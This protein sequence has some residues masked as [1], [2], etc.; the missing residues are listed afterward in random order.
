[1]VEVRLVCRLV[2]CACLRG[3]GPQRSLSFYPSQRQTAR[4]AHRSSWQK[5]RGSVGSLGRK[6]VL[7]YRTSNIGCNGRRAKCS[8]S[9]D[10]EYY[11]GVTNTSS[12]VRKQHNDGIFHSV[13]EYVATLVESVHDL[14]TEGCRGTP[15]G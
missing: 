7:G 3:E 10:K 9:R 12:S 8:V 13:Y 15:E 14:R 1:M 6:R 4:L 11:Q 2:K 5:T